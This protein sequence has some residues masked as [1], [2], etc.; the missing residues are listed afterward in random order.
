MTRRFEG[1]SAVITDET[2]G[3]GLATAKYFVAE[4]AKVFVTGRRQERLDQAVAALGPQA[5]GVQGDVTVQANLDRLYATV[6]AQVGTLDIM[7]ANAGEAFLARIG[8]YT[9][10]VIDQSLNLNMKGTI[11]T[12]QKA[13]PLMTRGGAVILHGSIEALRGSPG[14]G[15]YAATKAAL[16]AFA[17][18]WSVELGERGIRVNL[19]G[20]GVVYTAAYEAA[21]VSLDS[22]SAVIPFIPVGRLGTVNEIARAIGFLASEDSSFVTAADLVVDGGQINT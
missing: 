4:G 17:R 12:V 9:D 16:R 1:K 2:D 10:E 5:T 13:L 7:V 19:I 21:G 8:E 11:H 14:L 3:I 15:L 22:A 20:T 18:T 6:E